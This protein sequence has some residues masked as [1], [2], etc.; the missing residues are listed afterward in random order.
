MMMVVVVSFL[1]D[2]GGRKIDCVFCLFICFRIAIRIAISRSSLLVVV[3]AV[4][5]DDDGDD[6]FSVWLFF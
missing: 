4:A 2:V 1:G 5:A 3:V 6:N